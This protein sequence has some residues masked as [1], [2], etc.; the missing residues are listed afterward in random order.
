MN[1]EEAKRLASRY[2]A[3]DL[4]ELGAAFLSKDTRNELE[5]FVDNIGHKQ[6]RPMYRLDGD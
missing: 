4:L 1:K 5:E 6:A 3:K 2:L